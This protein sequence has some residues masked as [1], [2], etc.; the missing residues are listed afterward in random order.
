[1]SKLYLEF[2]DGS[3]LEGWRYLP[4]MAMVLPVYLLIALLEVLV[5]R[6]RIERTPTG[7]RFVRRNP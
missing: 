1:M 4:L 6:M 7:I 3:R 2:S 5:G